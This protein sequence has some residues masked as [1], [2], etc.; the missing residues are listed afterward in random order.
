MSA[1]RH[2]FSRSPRY[3]FGSEDESALR[4]AG[5][6][7]RGIIRR[8]AIRDLS[9]S[10]LAFAI[11]ETQAPEEGELLKIE[12]PIPGRKTIAC[13][14]TV[15]RVDKRSEWDPEWGDRGHTL[16]GLQFRNLPT[17][18]FR[19]IQRGLEGRV[20]NENFDWQKTRRTHAL[21]FTGLSI[22]LALGAWAMTH[23]PQTWLGYFRTFFVAI[24]LVFASSAAMADTGDT[25]IVKSNGTVQD[26]KG[27][28][29]NVLITGIGDRS[30]VKDDQSVVT[31]TSA[32]QIGIETV[33]GKPLK[34]GQVK[35]TGNLT[36]IEYHKLGYVNQK[37]EGI[38]EPVPFVSTVETIATFRI[39]QSSQTCLKLSAR[40]SNGTDPMLLLVDI[41]KSAKIRALQRP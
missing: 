26:S 25:V 30:F 17:L 23:S 38:A 7:T 40:A 5:M 27:K 2:Y 31:F 9:E 34:I 20:T 16:I 29:S 39:P 14:A 37:V 4:Y 24:A 28:E 18:H 8:A 33:N 11:G 19:A 12:F 35:C 13:F 32:F 3:V 1:A 10:G 21:A 6:N 36:T 15:V 22:A 41:G